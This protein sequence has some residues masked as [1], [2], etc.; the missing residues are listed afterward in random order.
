MKEKRLQRISH[1]IRDEISRYLQR[2]EIKDPGISGLP[3]VSYVRLSKDLQH[4]KIFVSVIGSESEQKNTISALNRAKNY[5]RGLLMKNLYMRRIP[6]LE[7][8]LD[9]SIAKAVDIVRKIDALSPREEED[10]DEE[11]DETLEDYP[12]GESEMTSA[13]IENPEKNS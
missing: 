13:K 6:K 11:L 3:T 9:N 4:A 1:Q 7:F 10:F 12:E 5:I 2:G 8:V